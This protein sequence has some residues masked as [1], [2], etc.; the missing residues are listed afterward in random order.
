MKSPQKSA[1]PEISLQKRRAFFLITIL[2]PLLLFV[3]LELFLRIIQYGPN[4][5]L[6]ATHTLRGREYCVMN[7][8]IKGRYFFQ[9]DF[10]PGTAPHYFLNPKPAGTYRIFCLGASTTVGYPYWFN[11]S[12]SA[13]LRDRLTAIFPNKNI[14]VINLGM[15]ATNSY[16]VADVARELP[17]VQ[18]DCIIVYDG[19]NEFYGALGVA[20][21]ES[22]GRLRWVNRLYLRLVR[23][24][25]VL[26]MR[27]LISGVAGLL[28]NSD[29][30]LPSGT[31]M[32]RLS[33]GQY[34][35]Y[36]SKMYREGLA[37][38][39]ENLEE[40]R[41]IC[42]RAGVP[43]IVSTQVS[44]IRRQP[45]FVSKSDPES[46]I[47]DRVAF[48]VA[49]NDAIADYLNGHFSSAL[50]KLRGITGHD[51]LRA[52][53]HFRI[54]QCLDTL[55]RPVEAHAEYVRAR[56]LDQLRFRASGDINNAIR[57]MADGAR[58]IVAD[59][60][61]AFAAS[62]PDSLTGNEFIVEHL[63]PNLSGYFMMAREYAGILRAHGFVGDAGEWHPADTLNDA[64][65]WEERS[66]TVLDEMVAARKTAILTSGW[67]FRDE[68]PTV[69]AIPMTDTLGEFV[70]LL[71][72]SRLSWKDAHM[73][74]AAYYS[75]HRNF[76]EAFREYRVVAI[77]LPLDP[78][79][80]VSLGELLVRAG[81]P[82]E[83]RQAF[84]RSLQREETT[85]AYSGLGGIALLAGAVTEAA[86]YYQK[87]VGI[88][89]TLEERAEGRYNL[90]LLYLRTGDRE[91]ARE[92]LKE[93]VR[94]MPSHREA[95]ELLARISQAR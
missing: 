16:T 73:E 61:K 38:F 26:L 15:T 4:L 8:E 22:P 10:R 24:R 59:L 45:P 11:G 20:S 95:T 42:V 13:F 91:R 48:N 44:N 58:V 69:T 17:Q 80:L 83:A 93:V 75:L 5:S 67:P 78:T 39:R 19:H 12:F 53:L 14:E 92:G 77:E 35:P 27:D 2:T 79:P 50:S 41:D 40:L 37:V 57:S 81:K 90:A 43:L 6:F 25:T 23:L 85:R 70:E 33:R 56:D 49:F 60:E 52:D 9:V 94:T 54:A 64:R 55:N 66:A 28:G 86:S 74:A 18:P 72:R 46:P 7:P 32:E 21:H 87:A 89:H 62:S 31:M 68:P 51:T 65:L 3:L 71:S 30:G 36:G 47:A 63:H 1:V 76:N 84:Q 34:V 82:D 29:D 88:S